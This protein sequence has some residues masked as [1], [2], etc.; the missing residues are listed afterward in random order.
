MLVFKTRPL[1]FKQ[2]IRS[3]Q[4]KTSEQ[5]RF[6]GK[7]KGWAPKEAAAL[8]SSIRLEQY[9]SLALNLDA[10][11]LGRSK[12][13]KHDSGRLIIAWAQLGSL[14]ECTLQLVLGVHLKNYMQDPNKILDRRDPKKLIMPHE[15]TLEGLRVFFDKSVWD[16]DEKLAWNPW[17]LDVQYHRNAIHALKARNMGTW[18]DLKKAVITYHEFLY[19]TDGR[20]PQPD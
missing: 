3:I 17:I 20:L 7:A 13:A 12:S 11:M 1:T 5:A 18:S 15:I 16:K 10:T 2:T 8:L 6:W 19:D 4:E 9:A 14:V